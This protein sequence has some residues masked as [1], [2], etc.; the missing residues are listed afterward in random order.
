MKRGLEGKCKGEGR[1]FIINIFFQSPKFQPGKEFL[2]PHIVG[3]VERF[4]EMAGWV[5]T[6]LVV[7]RN[8][9][10]RVSKLW[11][12]TLLIKELIFLGNFNGAMQVF[13]QFPF[14][15]QFFFVNFIF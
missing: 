13:F 6:E 15:P 9:S 3:M 12:F 5:A 7:E 11:Y 4:N 2:A 8:L 1:C 14:F 10:V